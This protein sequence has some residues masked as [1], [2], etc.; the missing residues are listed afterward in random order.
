MIGHAFWHHNIRNWKISRP[1]RP[2]YL[3]KRNRNTQMIYCIFIVFTSYLFSGKIFGPATG[4]LA[5]D[6]VGY[7]I[8]TCFP[9]STALLKDQT[10]DRW[11]S[12]SRLSQRK[13]K[14]AQFNKMNAPHHENFTTWDHY[15]QVDWCRKKSK[16]DYFAFVFLQNLLAESKCD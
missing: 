15:T 16:C 13:D 11:S 4:S 6:W 2:K 8:L 9:I 10:N 3:A 14:C 1:N 7:D 12:A 5:K